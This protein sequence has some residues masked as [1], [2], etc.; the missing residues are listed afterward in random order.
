[1]DDKARELVFTIANLKVTSP[2]ECFACRLWRVPPNANS[3]LHFPLLP[4]R[5][6][7]R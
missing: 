2:P 6:W 5:S 3:S 1:M 7:L 4:T